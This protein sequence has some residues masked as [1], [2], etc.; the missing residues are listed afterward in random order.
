VGET[1]SGKS[2][3]GLVLAERFNGE[4]ICADSRTVYRHL[5][6]GTAKPSAEEQARA[7]H[8]LLDV[9][10]PDQPFSA[11]EFKRLARQAIT[12]IAQRGKLP[13]MIG[14][15]GLYVDSVLFDFNFLPPVAAEE[16]RRLNALS[17]EELQNEIV[18]KGWQLPENSRNKRYLMRT[19]EVAGAERTRQPLRERTLVLQPLVPKDV[20][21]S[22]IKQRVEV[23]VERGFAEEAAKQANRYGWDAPGLQAPGY[24]AFRNYVGGRQTLEAAMTQFVRNDLHLAKRQHTWFKRNKSVSYICNEAEAVEFVTTWLNKLA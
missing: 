19:L 4:I 18:G 1:A 16:R 21:K 10:E 2:A 17:V 13:I 6:I 20:L 14:G 9:V 3:L 15:S 22:R 12:D 11:A 5:D 7:R 23:M 24:K 8:H